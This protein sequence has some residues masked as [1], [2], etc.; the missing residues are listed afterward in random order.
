MLQNPIKDENLRLLLA[1][2]HEDFLIARIRERFIANGAMVGACIGL[3]VL[4]HALSVISEYWV[5]YAAVVTGVAVFA[6]P[7]I[8]MIVCRN[9][10]M[11]RK[12]MR[13][14]RDHEEFME[15]Y[16]RAAD[17]DC[18]RAERYHRLFHQFSGSTLIMLLFLVFFYAGFA[19]RF[20]SSQEHEG[21]SVVSD[22]DVCVLLGFGNPDGIEE[23][24]KRGLSDK[25]CDA[26]IH[27]AKGQGN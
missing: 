6:S 20:Q 24:A 4:A 19:S 11:A 25:R 5:V 17:P 23:A 7:F 13:Y 16:N 26:I 18:L 27:A 21:I 3:P 15:R 14:Y 12:F 9:I 8:A 22:K 1:L 10:W 2:G